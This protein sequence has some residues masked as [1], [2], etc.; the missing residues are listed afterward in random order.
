MADQ[1]HLYPGSCL[2]DGDGCPGWHMG[3]SRRQQINIPAGELAET[4]NLR[5][6]GR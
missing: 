6:V 1:F 3:A 4:E 2:A 5:A